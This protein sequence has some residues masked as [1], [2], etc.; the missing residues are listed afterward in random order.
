MPTFS[1]A[2]LEG[3]EASGHWGVLVPAR[4]PPGIVD[5]L[6]KAFIAGVR[7]PAV[8]PRLE[9]LGFTPL[10]EGPQHYANLLGV[11]IERWT[12]VIRNANIRVD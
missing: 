12:R 11:E 9:G 4:T 3:L 6:A 10:G 1:E 2:G 5:K 7:D 8:A